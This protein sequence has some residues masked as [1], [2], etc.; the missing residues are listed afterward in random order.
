MTE[1]IWALMGRIE[2]LLQNSR[3]YEAIRAVVMKCRDLKYPASI[4]WDDI[5]DLDEYADSLIK[6]QEEKID[7]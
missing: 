3:R 1:N 7:E 2:E 5:T 4:G 6:N